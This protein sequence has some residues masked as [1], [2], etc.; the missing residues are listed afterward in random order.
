MKTDNNKN[1][2]DKDIA[3]TTYRQELREI[4]DASWSYLSDVRF[5]G[6]NL[7]SAIGDDDMLKLATLKALGEERLHENEWTEFATGNVIQLLAASFY[8][9]GWDYRKESEAALIECYEEQIVND[10]E[11]EMAFLVADN[12]DRPI[13]Q[14]QAA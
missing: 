4:V 12:A 11:A 13:N 6:C 9:K 5:W 10:I 2:L 7:R 14:A 8:E 3:K 1:I